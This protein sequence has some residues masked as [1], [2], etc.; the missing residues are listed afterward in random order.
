MLLGIVGKPSV[1]KSSFFKAATLA[2]AETAPHPFTTIKPNHAIGYVKVECPAENLYKKKCD[3]REGYCLDGV[4]FVPVE[5]LDVAGLVPGA[6]EGKGL[7]NKFLSDLSAADVLLHIVDASGSTNELGEEIGEGK[8]DVTKDVR[9]LEEEIDMWFFSIIS[10]T[11]DGIS[12]KMKLEKSDVIKGLFKQFS[13]LKITENNIRNAITKTKLDP[14][15]YSEWSEDDLK[16]LC[17]EMR[18]QSK[19]IIIVANKIDREISKKNIEKLKKEFPDTLVIPCSAESE[20]ALRMAAKNEVIDYVPGE[21]D[22]T[23]KDESKLN[24]E[25]KK[26]LEQIKSL[27]KTYGSTGV[28]EALD[29]AVFEFLHYIAIFPGGMNKLEDSKGNVLP[30]C[31]LMPECTTALE[32][33]FNIHSDIGEGFIKAMDVKEKRVVGKE[34]ELKHCDIVEIIT[35]N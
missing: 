26:G 32:F 33:A 10:K 4:R 8:H 17:K 5:L 34:H 20:Y 21:K 22:F 27:L 25:Q 23:I 31:F 30:D 28:Q 14:E 24:E 29:K 11:W 18:K 13:G 12:K 16:S 9:F 2:E 19:P 7:G 6:Y 1:G 35:R 3:P 15:K